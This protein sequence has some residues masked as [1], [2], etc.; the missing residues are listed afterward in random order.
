[1]GFWGKR[2]ASPEIKYI[3]VLVS[4]VMTRISD[5]LVCKNCKN[6]FTDRVGSIRSSPAICPACKES[7]YSRVDYDL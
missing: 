1:M 4:Y 3:L 5:L 7:D 2:N 6:I